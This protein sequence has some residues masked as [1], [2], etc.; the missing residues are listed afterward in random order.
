MNHSSS[1]VATIFLLISRYEVNSFVPNAL[2]NNN[3][4]SARSDE[5]SQGHGALHALAPS[6]II[7]PMLK[8]MREKEEQKK[9]PMANREEAK[10]EAP[11]LR[12]G[13]SSWKWPPVWPYDSTTFKPMKDVQVTQN[14]EKKLA[15]ANMASGGVVNPQL[16]DGLTGGGE[17]DSENSFDPVKYWGEE[18][19]TVATD[20]SEG[21]ANNLK[22]QVQTTVIYSCSSSQ[23]LLT[24]VMRLQPL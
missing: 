6:F 19:A 20:I 8:K 1:I 12:V 16:T 2:P 21:A 14:A 11:G 3:I 10:N 23:F 13:Q 24:K 22:R 9:M 18:M 15:L 5:K 7:G 17:G 4:I